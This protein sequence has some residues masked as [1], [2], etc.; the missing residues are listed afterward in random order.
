MTQSYQETIYSQN[1]PSWSRVLGVRVKTLFTEIPLSIPLGDLPAGCRFLPCFTDPLVKGYQCSLQAPKRETCYLPAIGSHENENTPNQTDWAGHK[2]D[3]AI[4][5]QATEAVTLKIQLTGAISKNALLHC[6]TR[7]ASNTELPPKIASKRVLDV[8]VLSQMT[9]SD[10]IKK[11]ICSPVSA[12]MVLTWHGI[13]VD[14]PAFIQATR[15]QASK[16]YGVWPSNMLAISHL[17]LA[18]TVRYFNNLQEVALLL[19]QNMPVPVSIS[20]Q[21]GDLPTAPM[22]QTQGHVVVVTGIQDNKVYVND[23][24]AL[25]E[26]EVARCYPLSAF[27]QAWKNHHR[28]GYLISPMNT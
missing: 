9:M 4:L 15:H 16:L 28:I 21:E 5:Q 19:D 2:I 26:N 20:Y 7:L 1:P 11:Q 23:P 17:G 12:L 6:S 10:Q 18:A 14:P 25:T 3:W 27:N 24:A 22:P 8:P 13:E